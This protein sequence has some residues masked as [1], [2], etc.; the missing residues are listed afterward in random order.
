MMYREEFGNDVVID[1]VGYR[2]YGHNEGDEPAYSQPGMYAVIEEHASVRELYQAQLVDAGVIA[3][4]EADA[5]VKD[6]QRDLAKRQASVR[7]GAEE[8]QAELD[9]GSEAIAPEEPAEPETAV[10]IEELREANAG[11]GAVPDGFTIHPKLA[12]QLERRAVA[13]DADKAAVDWGH[14]ELLAFATLLR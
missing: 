2:K 14:A 13:L 9:R 1:L 5:M 8:P 12:R 11:L 6:A 3:A 10:P 7:K 4:D